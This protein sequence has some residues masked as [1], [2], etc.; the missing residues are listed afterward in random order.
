VFRG[1]PGTSATSRTP[2]RIRGWHERGQG[3]SVAN[4][5]DHSAA[6]LLN[7]DDN[8]RF[9]GL[10]GFNDRNGSY[11]GREDEKLRR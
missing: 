6:I 8:A 2:Q 5:R 10:W 11:L 3:R 1:L 9:D 4:N 7:R